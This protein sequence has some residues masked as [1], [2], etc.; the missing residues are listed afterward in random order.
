[1]ISFII[2]A[3]GESSRFGELKQLHKIRGRSFLELILTNLS[4]LQVKKEIIVGVGYEKKKIFTELKKS[5]LSVKIAV[6]EN[7]KNGQ[8]S[9]FKECLKIS[10][11]E[12]EGY[13]MVLS[14]H[15]LIKYSTYEQLINTFNDNKEKI[16]IPEYKK[17]KGHPIIFPKELKSNLLDA[18]LD[19]GA[20]TVIKENPGKVQLVPVD[21]PFI[22]ADIDDKEI[23][24]E[25]LKKI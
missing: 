10:D 11:A 7:Y 18:P 17:R 15:P 24:K 14:D 16:I 12:S 2:L 9:T 5:R 20:R 8:L 21:D 1:M 4:E 25:Y 3:A 13:M 6:N 19:Q 23:L 22:H